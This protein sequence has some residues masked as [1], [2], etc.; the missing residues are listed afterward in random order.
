[1]MKPIRFSI[2]GGG[3]RANFYLK[4]AAMLPDYFQV[5]DVY[6]RNQYNASSFERHGMFV[7]RTRSSS[8]SNLPIRNSSCLRYP[9]TLLHLCCWSYP[10][11][12]CPC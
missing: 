7:R 10:S 2:L 3:W 9:K 12:R 5:Q 1:M 11:Y 4:I 8:C 6:M